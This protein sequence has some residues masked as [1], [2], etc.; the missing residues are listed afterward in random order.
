MAIAIYPRA[1]PAFPTHQNLI[2][3]VDASHVNNIQREITSIASVLGTFPQVYNDL[4]VP[5]VQTTYTPG[6]EGGIDPETDFTGLLRYYD[7]TITPINHGSISNRL[8]YIQ[9][10]QQNHCFKLR[11]SNISISR[12]TS[13]SLSAKPKAVRFPKPST[14]NDPF[15]MY[16][17]SGVTLRKSGFWTFHGNILYTLQGTNTQNDGMYVAAIDRQGNWLDG[18]HRRPVEPTGT[19]QSLN[20]T[21]S[22]FFNRGDVVKL[23][24]MHNSAVTQKIR[25]ASLSGFL[26]REN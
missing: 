15:T 3:D 17:G 18:I 14:T 22:G 2:D 12:S 20:V 4:T 1:I 5:Q 26:I 23:R 10:G 11:A 6:D 25:I 13:V 21:L 16:N 19:A 8:D 7:P 9:K 24:S